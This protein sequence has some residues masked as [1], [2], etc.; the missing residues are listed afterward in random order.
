[1]PLLCYDCNRQTK[2]KLE[3]ENKTKHVFLYILILI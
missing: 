3:D 2:G 1:M